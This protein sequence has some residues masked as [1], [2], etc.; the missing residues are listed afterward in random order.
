[1]PLQGLRDEACRDAKVVYDNRLS[2]GRQNL[3]PPSGPIELSNVLFAP[4]V[5][6]NTVAGLLCLANIPT[7]FNDHDAAMASVLGGLAALALRRDRADEELNK[8]GRHPAGKGDQKD[9]T[10]PAG[11]YLHR[12]L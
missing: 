2:T 4:L 11:G 5:I 9:P 8:T 7:D 6:E 3:D 1:M 12:L 10:P